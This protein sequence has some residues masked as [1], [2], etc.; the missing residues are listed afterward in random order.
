MSVNR[1]S[2]IAYEIVWSD[3]QILDIYNKKAAQSKRKNGARG[4]K[5]ERGQASTVDRDEIS[6]V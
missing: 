2:F 5:N 1:I 3:L 4:S 6:R